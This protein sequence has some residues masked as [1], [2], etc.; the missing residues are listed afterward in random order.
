MGFQHRST[1]QSFEHGK[2]PVVTAVFGVLATQE[3]W[4][5]GVVVRCAVL[6]QPVF[7]QGLRTQSGTGVPIFVQQSGF[8]D[9]SIC[10]EFQGV[11]VQCL[12]VDQGQEGPA[13]GSLAGSAAVGLNAAAVLR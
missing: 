13:M 1:V 2:T 12:K 10:S 5:R 4:D 9:P 8:P 6:F 7:Q 3:F 11:S